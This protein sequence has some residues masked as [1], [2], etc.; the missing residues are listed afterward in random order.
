MKKT[1]ATKKSHIKL[2]ILGGGQLGRMSALAA[3]RLGIETHIFAPEANS[4]AFQVTPH[5]TVADYDDKK[6]L[7]QFAE[8]VDVITYE[9]ENIPLE[10]VR[11][12]ESYAPVYPKPVLLEVSQQRL[13][14]KQFLNDLGIPTARWAAIM[15]P[16]DIHSFYKKNKI[17]NCILKTIRFGYDGKGQAKLSAKDN[18]KK[19]WA[20]FKQDIMIAEEVID[21]KHE[22]SVI[23][24]RDI[25]GK[26]CIYDPSLNLHKD[27]ILDTSTVPCGLSETVIKTAT[28]YTKKIADTVDLVGV[29]AVEFFV[30]KAGKVLANEIA[31]RTHNSGHWTIDACTVS[32][33]E[34]HV[35]CVCGLPAGSGKRHSNAVMKNLIGTAIY[36]TAPYY[37]SPSFALHDYGKDEAKAGRKMG[38]VTQI[39]PLSPLSP[40]S[41]SK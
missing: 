19:A 28:N 12:L 36:D 7:R 11:Y 6:R 31:P 34:N 24:A 5:F 41:K 20:S 32:Q 1:K 37:K 30:T 40:R 26:T 22:I 25:F 29:L 3:A 39:F 9:F 27:H 18:A 17:N 38:H 35:R 16:D 13:K 21:F 14:E 2:G 33:F 23:I 15:S 8:S 4:P 10:T